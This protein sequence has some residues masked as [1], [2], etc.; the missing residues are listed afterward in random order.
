MLSQF[1]LLSERGDTLVY[2]DYRGDIVSSTPDIFYRRIKTMQASGGV[3]PPIFNVEGT[4]F[5][6]IIQYGLYLSL[7]H[8]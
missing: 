3:P 6:Y 8:I 5:I 4:Q 2:R 7:I 1:F